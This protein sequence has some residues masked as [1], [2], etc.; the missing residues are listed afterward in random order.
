MNQSELK[1]KDNQMD[2]ILTDL[3]PKGELRGGPALSSVTDLV[4]DPRTTATGAV[5]ATNNRGRLIVGV[6]SVEL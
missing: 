4:I 1:N 6:D 2:I 3:E 5:A